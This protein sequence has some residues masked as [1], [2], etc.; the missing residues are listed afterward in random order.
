MLEGGGEVNG[1]QWRDPFVSNFA[2]GAVNLCRFCFACSTT[3]QGID[4]CVP[5]VLAWCESRQSVL[6]V[7]WHLEGSEKEKVEL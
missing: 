6:Q 3:S 4:F 5:P 7:W 1:R 2:I